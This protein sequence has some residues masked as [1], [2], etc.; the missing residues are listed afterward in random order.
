MAK[1]KPQDITSFV[2]SEL[3]AGTSREAIIGH[4]ADK[5]VNKADAEKFVHSVHSAAV[6]VAKKEKVTGK[7]LPLA[8]L[9]AV[10]ASLVGGVLWGVLTI[11]TNYEFGFAALGVG[12]LSGF[13]VV[14]LSGGKKG[15]ELQVAAAAASVLGIILGKYI[16]FVHA[17]GKVLAEEV[18]TEISVSYFSPAAIT[19]FTGNPG[20]SFGA[21]DILWVVI[22]V[23]AAWQ[24]PKGI[25]IK[26]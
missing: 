25:G 23:A 6:D 16:I 14:R 21:F 17:V 12:F 8:I 4:L 2:V 1:Q 9:G 15:V 10:L 11:V 3:K 22:A 18:G 5:G 7:S 19:M 20:L 24:I 13:A 26:G